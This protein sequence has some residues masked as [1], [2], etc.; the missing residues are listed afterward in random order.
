MSTL[1][2]APQRPNGQAP[3]QRSGGPLVVPVDSMSALS[4]GQKGRLRRASEKKG[5]EGFF[6]FFPGF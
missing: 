2:V 4:D 5:V 3:G 6:I 1:C